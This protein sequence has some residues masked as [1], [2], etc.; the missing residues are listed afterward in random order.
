MAM[1]KLTAPPGNKVGTFLNFPLA[2]SL[3]DLQAHFAILGIPF[4]MP[5]DASSMA[6]DQ[7]TAPDIIRQT[8]TM[9]DALN[10]DNA[11]VGSLLSAFGVTITLL[12]WGAVL[13]MPTVWL[14]AI[15]ILTAYCAYWGTFRFTSYSSDI[16]LMSVTMAG[17]LSVGK[18][19]I[20]CHADL[21]ATG[22][23]H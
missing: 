3:D 17:A 15:I 20:R 2:S 1:K 8:P 5:Y 21:D 13:R 11:H 16:F 10:L 4:G 12:F 23:G 19:W 9:A 22:D 18:L 14:I 6:N 7:S